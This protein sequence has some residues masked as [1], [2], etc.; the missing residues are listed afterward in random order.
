VDPLGPPHDEWKIVPW[1]L[2]KHRTVPANA[3]MANVVQ[4]RLTGME[5]YAPENLSL[6]GRVL[7]GYG[8]ENVLG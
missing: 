3:V 5:A 1:G 6:K 7:Q 4:Q 2:P 8:V